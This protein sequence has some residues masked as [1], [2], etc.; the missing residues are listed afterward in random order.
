MIR[1][2][3]ESWYISWSGWEVEK[4]LWSRTLGEQS[5]GVGVS[6]EPSGVVVAS[7]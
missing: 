4:I 7:E 3:S 2:R 6:I 5:T 1:D